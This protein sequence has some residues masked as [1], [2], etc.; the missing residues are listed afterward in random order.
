[1]DDPVKYPLLMSELG[2]GYTVFPEF[3]L[4]IA[5]RIDQ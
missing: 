4:P 2:T 1:M 3:Y 5:R